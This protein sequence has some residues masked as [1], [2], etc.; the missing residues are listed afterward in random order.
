[1]L[2]DLNVMRF[3]VVCAPN[4]GLCQTR[5]NYIFNVEELSLSTL[6]P[7][8]LAEVD[9]LERHRTQ[10][11]GLLRLAGVDRAIHISQ[12]ILYDD[13]GVARIVRRRV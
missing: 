6:F 3:R 11:S 13:T 7:Y 12:H 10:G 5:P 9:R 1:M 4:G 2:T 8:F